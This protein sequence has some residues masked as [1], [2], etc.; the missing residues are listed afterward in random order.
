MSVIR[1]ISFATSVNRDITLVLKK[2]WIVYG[3]CRSLNVF[4]QRNKVKYIITV[5]I[6]GYHQVYC[7]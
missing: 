3:Y 7:V 4:H 5:D 1:P 2:N 6:Q